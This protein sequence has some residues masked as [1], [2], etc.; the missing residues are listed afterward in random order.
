VEAFV[1]RPS[2]VNS[3]AVPL[4]CDII[5]HDFNQLIRIRFFVLFNNVNMPATQA[6]QAEWFSWSEYQ[7]F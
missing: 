2:T 7:L 4:N 1:Q 5:E 3:K 6:E